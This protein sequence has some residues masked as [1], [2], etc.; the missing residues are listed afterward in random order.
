MSTWSEKQIREAYC[1]RVESQKPS[2]ELLLKTRRAM[3]AA[4]RTSKSKFIFGRPALRAIATIAAVFVFVAGSFILL[5]HFAGDEASRS[6]ARKSA[7]AAGSGSQSLDILDAPAEFSLGFTEVEE[8]QVE[9]ESAQK[10][11]SARVT[12]STETPEAAQFHDPLENAGEGTFAA[13]PNKISSGAKDLDSRSAESSEPGS[14]FEKKRT[15]A[16]GLDADEEDS[17][18]SISLFAAPETVSLASD[19]VRE[20]EDQDG[21]AESP[22]VLLVAL[23]RRMDDRA[24]GQISDRIVTS[25]RQAGLELAPT[26]QIIFDKS[27]DFQRNDFRLG[28]IQALNRSYHQAFT[29]PDNSEALYLFFH[30]AKMDEQREQLSFK[31]SIRMAGVVLDQF[32]VTVELVDGIWKEIGRSNPE[33]CEDC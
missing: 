4:A 14:S 29:Q 33:T 12:K 24:Y 27:P 21:S 3:K 7:P 8:K 15:S 22:Q 2:T 18:E 26:L 10:A 19:E 31:V 20:G 5:Q 6:F 1:R 11:K 23:N 30:S 17:P 16:E 9:T 32:E 28:L 25:L 13:L